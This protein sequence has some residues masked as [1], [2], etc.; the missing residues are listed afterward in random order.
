M[1]QFSFQLL[2][3]V[4]RQ[5]YQLRP[6]AKNIIQYMYHLATSLILPNM[7]MGTAWF[8][9]PSFP[10]R[11]VSHILLFILS[12][13]TRGGLFASKQTPAKTARVS[14]FCPSTFSHLPRINLCATQALHDSAKSHE[15][16]RWAF[17][18]YNFWCWTIHRGLS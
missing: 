14:D 2:L 9:L 4:T 5:Q 15:M 8:L 3:A 7:D 10:S 16:P 13:L 6:V 12:F 11:R 1:D 17:S 18:S